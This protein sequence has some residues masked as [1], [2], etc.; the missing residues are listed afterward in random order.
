VGVLLFRTRLGYALRVVGL[1]PPA[2]EYGGI[3][4]GRMQALAM[5]LSGA[6]AGLGSVSF[7]L[8]YKRFFEMGFSAGAGFLG[9]AVALL[10]RNHPVGVVIAALFF[11]ALSHGGFVINQRVPRDLV[12]VLQALV[13]LFAIAVQQV[14]E[15]AAR[16]MA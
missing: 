5:A 2:A 11:G 4:P 14:L 1:S 13:I 8:G 7:V 12:E 10:G 15:R 3:S 9:I 6:V 16:R